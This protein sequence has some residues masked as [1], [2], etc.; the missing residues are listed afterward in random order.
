[1]ENI[2]E[3]MAQSIRVGADLF[4]TF[5]HYL[6]IIDSTYMEMFEKGHAL[7]YLTFGFQ[8]KHV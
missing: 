1:V 8:T 5:Q 7:I 2:S 3:G 4:P 6:F